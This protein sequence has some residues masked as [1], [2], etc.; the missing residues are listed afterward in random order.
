ML[1]WAAAGAV[2]VSTSPGLATDCE[3]QNPGKV[4]SVAGPVLYVDAAN[5]LVADIGYRKVVA[6]NDTKR[7]CTAYVQARTVSKC[8]K[9]KTTTAKGTT[10][11]IPFTPV[12]LPGADSVKCH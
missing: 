7:G 4:F 8:A 10:F 3:F 5:D 9:G 6:I 11:V 2:I 1:L 12:V